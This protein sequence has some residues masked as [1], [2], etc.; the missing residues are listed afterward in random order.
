MEHM[1]ATQPTIADLEA[2]Q[3]ELEQARDALTDALSQ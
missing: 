3:A 1:A 2:A